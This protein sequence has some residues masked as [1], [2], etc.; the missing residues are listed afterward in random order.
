MGAAASTSQPMV[1]ALYHLHHD[2]QLKA[3]VLC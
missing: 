1:S 2:I 3:E